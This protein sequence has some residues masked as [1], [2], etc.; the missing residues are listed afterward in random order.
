M[1]KRLPGDGPGAGHTDGSSVARRRSRQLK[2]GAARPR[3]AEVGPATTARVLTDRR[4]R[5]QQQRPEC[6]STEGRA[7]L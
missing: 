1:R 5:H 2:Q 3:H 6:P 4:G 7:L